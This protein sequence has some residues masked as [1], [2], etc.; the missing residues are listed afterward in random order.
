MQATPLECLLNPRSIAMIGATPRA[1]SV[2]FT[3]RL[4][5][6]NR[7]LGYG[8]EIFLVNPNYDSIL[9]H[10]A[11][12]SLASI[13]KPVDA[14][15]ISLPGERVIA[16][17]AEAI[18][19]GARALVVHSGG[20]A[21]R[22]AQGRERQEQLQ[23]MCREAGIPMLGPNCLGLISFRHRA[24]LSSL[25]TGSQLAAGPIAAISQSGSIASA[26]HGIGAR[27][28][29]SILAST[30]NEAV[31]TAEDLMAWAVD[32]EQTRVIVA[33]IEGFRQPRALAALAQRA[34]A[35]GKPIIVL[36]SGLTE[37]G[38]RVSRGHS[39]ALAGP[40]DVLRQALRQA[41]IVQVKDLD[42]LA[43]T[44]ELFTRVRRR[45]PSSRVAL[46]ATS[47]GELGLFADA[48][49]NQQLPTP[50]LGD[51]TVHALKQ[52]LR[53]P[54][55]AVQANP[56]DVGT[57]F[58]NP[59]SYQDRMRACIR[60]V[61]ADP[62]IDV[63]AVVQGY[64][65]DNPDP[66]FSL[67]AQMLGAAAK[68]A[69]LLDKPVLTI[70]SRMGEGDATIMSE[71]R[72]G[73]L[74]MLEGM[75]ESIAALVH[76]DGFARKRFDSFRPE[77]PLPV[78]AQ[79]ERP[80][81]F[82]DGT[83]PQRVLFPLLEQCGIAATPLLPAHDAQRAQALARELGPRVVMKVDTGRV[84]HKSDVGGVALDVTDATAPAAFERV[85]GCLQPPVGSL[86]GESVVVAAQ[87]DAGVEFFVGA[88]RDE[89]FGAVVMCGIG[90]RW[91]EALGRTA[92]LVAPFTRHDALAA[93]EE[94]GAARLLGGVRGAPAADLEQ[95]AE[96]VMRVGALAEALEDRLEVLEF[97][98]VII[99][100]A[101]PGGVVADAR[102]ILRPEASRA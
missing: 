96:L 68:E 1:S 23:R 18:A 39:G 79:L 43:Q 102:L 4:L 87:L 10:K 99:N 54:D 93:I 38:S 90:G 73:G 35:L 62:S 49:F 30:G 20:F 75:A 77:L 98:P 101:H 80:A 76:L 27:H 52:V 100:A 91:V 63:V 88:T 48:A 94:S 25:P 66:A 44:V 67:N 5:Q 33:F 42:E 40:G 31:T 85:R 21:E 2:S 60:A 61:A 56:V 36:K 97:N 7:S 14:A 65:Q 70:S 6:G 82:P 84:V 51:D 45:L 12:P 41:G 72:E 74:V 69:P 29:L 16:A 24:A 37:A 13:G 17:A 92:R 50:P 34:H 71:A 59:A 53:L 58:E 15:I 78:L 32:D 64:H 9:E 28:G 19:A 47:G 8:G 55:E 26:L 57:G 83:V 46:L 95:L 22:S 11:W 3:R 86:P 81:H 89:S